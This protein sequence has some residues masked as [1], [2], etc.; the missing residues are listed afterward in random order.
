MVQKSV[1]YILAK[2]QCERIADQLRCAY[3]HAEANNRA[4]RL[5][6]WLEK[7]G[8]IVATSTPLMYINL[9]NSTI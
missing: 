7:G 4:K 5:Q 8:I 6:E 9:S 2:A 3:Y 1:V